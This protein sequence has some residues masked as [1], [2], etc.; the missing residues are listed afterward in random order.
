MQFPGI[1]WLA[2]SVAL[3]FAW[4]LE[5]AGGE[6]E[7]VALGEERELR[8][9][10][11]RVGVHHFEPEEPAWKGIARRVL[12]EPW[13]EKLGLQSG[14]RTSLLLSVGEYDV[15]RQDF[16]KPTFA[17]PVVYLD[18]ERTE[19]GIQRNTRSNICLIE[20][21]K[22][23]RRDEEVRIEVRRGSEPV[24]FRIR[25]PEKARRA[26][27]NASALPQTND[28]FLTQFVLE[29]R[30][31]DSSHPLG[32]KIRGTGRDGAKWMSVRTEVVDELGNWAELGSGVRIPAEA[33]LMTGA[34]LK[35]MALGTEYISAGMAGGPGAGTAREL[36]PEVRALEL[37]LKR[38]F[39][40]G[41]GEY[42]LQEEQSAGVTAVRRNATEAKVEYLQGSRSISV[43]CNQPSLLLLVE[44]K[45][46]QIQMKGRL[47]ERRESDRDGKTFHSRSAIVA[48]NQVVDGLTAKLFPIGIATDQVTLEVEVIVQHAPVVFYVPAEMFDG[49]R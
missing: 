40:M 34:T 1:V 5:A 7:R 33:G 46:D 8:I 47:R 37:G 9:L 25:N 6:V 23:P 35:L 44:E 32:L 18:G 19:A 45:V 48:T 21:R 43:K 26:R 16:V 36:V 15:K 22:Y 3:G 41:E 20:F 10:E 24:R 49:K 17:N 42:V 29:R 38:I 28:L 14:R 13:R 4:T 39:L 11:A 2:V 30:Q 27:W 31:N 12:S